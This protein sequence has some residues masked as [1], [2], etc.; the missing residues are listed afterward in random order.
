MKILGIH[1][2]AAPPTKV[3][4]F[5]YNH[6]I[7]LESQGHSI[8]IPKLDDTEDPDYISWEKDLANIDMS[9]YDTIIARSYGGGV[10]ARYIKNNNLHLKRVVFCGTG[11]SL[12]KRKNTG[13]LYDYLETHEMNLENNI[14]E[15]YIVHSKDDEIVPY[16]EWV[17]FQKQVWWELI[18]VSWV[19]HKLDGSTIEII[20]NLAVEWKKK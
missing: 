19:W 1:G 4:S 9:S 2:R 18:T 11:R 8:D 3:T 20:R 14:E 15:I 6:I 17:K 10:L 5:W 13:E 7:L 12:S 16:S